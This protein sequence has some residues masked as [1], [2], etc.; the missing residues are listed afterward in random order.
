MGAT[1]KKPTRKIYPLE[2]IDEDGNIYAIFYPIN[3]RCQLL[4]E[5]GQ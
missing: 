2:I 4:P 5:G 3:S 1:P